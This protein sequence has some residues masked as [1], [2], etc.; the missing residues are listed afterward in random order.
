MLTIIL[1]FLTVLGIFI[2]TKKTQNQF[3]EEQNQF[4][5]EKKDND[6]HIGV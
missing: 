1:M 3:A 4:Q 5:K 2:Y 6:N